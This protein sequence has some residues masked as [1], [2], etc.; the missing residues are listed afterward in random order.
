LV[1]GALLCLQAWVKLPLDPALWNNCR[2]TPGQMYAAQPRLFQLLFQVLALPGMVEEPYTC[3]RLADIAAELLV[4]VL[5][6]S[7]ESENPQAE[8]AALEAIMGS[9]VNL[10]GGL[11]S[12]ETSGLIAKAVAT[13]AAAVA[14]RDADAVCSSSS[15]SPTA[16]ALA[17][18]VLECLRSQQQQPAQQRKVCEAAADYFLAINTV[19]LAERS[20]ALG[21]PLFSAL[22]GPLFQAACHPPGWSDWDECDDDE[23][24]FHL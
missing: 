4:D 22:A 13:V 16:G 6:S 1:H 2:A 3:E 9:L 17:E 19:P 20:P 8:A 24:A 23:E 14:Q 10:R 5:G 11:Q 12:S 18:T 7:V 15:S 21:P